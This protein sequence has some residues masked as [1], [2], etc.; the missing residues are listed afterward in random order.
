M[1]PDDERRTY[2]VP[3]RDPWNPHIFQMLKYIDKLQEFYISTGDSFYEEQS[4]IIRTAVH[5]LKN[6]I[7]SLEGVDI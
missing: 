4:K 3:S 6:K 2:F 7:K 5:D 1:K